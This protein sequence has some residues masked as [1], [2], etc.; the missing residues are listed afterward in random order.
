MNKTVLLILAILN[1]PIFISFASMLFGKGGFTET[2]RYAFTPDFISALRGEF[3]EDRWAELMFAV[4]L[5]ICVA[6]VLAE[7]ACIKNNFPS[8]I[9]F[10]STST[11]N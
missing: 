11:A 9:A 6:L 8:V 5:V 10:F 3:W 2:L 1:I 7:Y 4:W